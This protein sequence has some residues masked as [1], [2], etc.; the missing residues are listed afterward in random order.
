MAQKSHEKWLEAYEGLK[1]FIEMRLWSSENDAE[2]LSEMPQDEY[3]SMLQKVT[4]KFV[5][6]EDFLKIINEVMKKEVKASV[7]EN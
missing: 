5:E 4:E 7:Y 2:I 6:D 3:E 1:Y